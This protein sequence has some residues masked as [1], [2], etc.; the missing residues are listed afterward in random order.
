LR[1]TFDYGASV[2]GDTTKEAWRKINTKNDTGYGI[3]DPREDRTTSAK[4][5]EGFTIMNAEL[6]ALNE[7]V[8]MAMGRQGGKFAI[9][10]DSRAALLTI[11][12]DSRRKNLKDGHYTY[13]T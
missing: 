5:K 13:Y 9:L 4:L 10:T 1:T 6:A 12:E 8:S 3:Y 2:Y 7:A 11:Y